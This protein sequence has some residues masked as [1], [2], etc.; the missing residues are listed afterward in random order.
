MAEHPY[1]REAIEGATMLG[2][3]ALTSA[4]V[5][6]FGIGHFGDPAIPLMNRVLGAQ[7]AVLMVSTYTLVLLALLTERRLREQQLHRLLGALPA[8]AYTTDK[9]GRITLCNRR[10]LPCGALPRLGAR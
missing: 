8:A 10:L 7:A 6:S 1:R 9:K 3:L 4:Y 2:L 5:V